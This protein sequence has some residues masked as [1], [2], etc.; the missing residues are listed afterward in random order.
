MGHIFI[1]YSRRDTGTV[2]KIAQKLTEAG[3]SV[4]LDREDIKTGNTWRVQ[5]VEAIDTCAAFLLVLSRYSSISDNVRKEIDLAQDSGRK[6]FVLRLENVAIPSEI[7][8]QLAGLQFAEVEELGFEPALQRIIEAV[9]DLPAIS[10]DSL[11]ISRQAELVVDGVKHGSFNINQQNKL[12][13]LL[14][15]L[16]DIDLSQL[17]IAGFVSGNNHVFVDMP[18]PAAFE[19]KTMALNNDKRLKK[20]GIRALRLDG[21][22]RFIKISF[23]ILG[24][25]GILVLLRS[26]RVRIL[27]SSCGC[28]T[29]LCLGVIAWRLLPTP[30]TQSRD[31]IETSNIIT[32]TRSTSA[33]RNTIT[34]TQT[35]TTEIITRF[36]ISDPDC[37][38]EIPKA[39]VYKGPSK[40]YL[41]ASNKSYNEEDE[42][43]VMN[44]D[45][46]GTWLFGELPDGVR[47]WMPIEWLS[48]SCYKPIIPTASYIPP[49]PPTSWP[50]PKPPKH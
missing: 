12:L 4:W 38:V 23:G 35:E 9:T 19:L 29:C 24:L 15:N 40:G 32:A 6:I 16:L 45:R 1:S 14:A 26:T 27:L 13:N 28:I 17:E 7:R 50:T 10:K 18:T 48:K 11:P 3:L 47:G 8:Y 43:I 31:I 34:S 25:T 30:S 21:N 20:T 22:K 36:P 39:F 41:L 42:F 37:H 5:I 49:L 2:D 46:T 33:P 44:V